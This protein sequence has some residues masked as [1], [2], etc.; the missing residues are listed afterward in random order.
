MNHIGDTIERKWTCD[1][2]KDTNPFV[3][4]EYGAD[5]SQTVDVAGAI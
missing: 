1:I 2:N 5:G 3:D 4:G